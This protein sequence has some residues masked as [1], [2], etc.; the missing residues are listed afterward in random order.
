MHLF[1][2]PSSMHSKNWNYP[3]FSVF[4]YMQDKSIY[5]HIRYQWSWH[6]HFLLLYLC[7]SIEFKHVFFLLERLEN[8]IYLD[9]DS[10]N[11]LSFSISTLL[12]HNSYTRK[13]IG[14]LYAIQVSSTMQL[15][16]LHVP[17][18]GTIMSENILHC[19]LC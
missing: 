5:T 3:T 19:W 14:Y 4:H 12:P 10:Q 15:D 2:C 8:V 13:M 7:K 11:H 18:F 9:I 16:R 1:T 17:Y 6:H